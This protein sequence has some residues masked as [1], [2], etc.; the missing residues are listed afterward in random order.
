[1]TLKIALIGSAPSSVALAP[2]DDPSWCI[3]ACSPGARPHLKKVDAFYE[4][5][6]WEP[7]QPWFAPEYVNWMANL[8]CPV[9]MLEHIDAIPP[10]VPYPKD[11]MLAKYGPFFFTSSLSWMFA[12]AIEAGATEIA[13]FGVDMS[14]AEEIYTHQRAGCHF[15]IH[16]AMKRGIKVT[17]P[18]QSDLMRPS[19]LYGFCEQDHLHQKMLAREAELRQRLTQ[20]QQQFEQSRNDMIYLQGALEDVRYVRNTWV[21][22]R[23]AIDMTV[24]REPPAEPAQTPALAPLT[25]AT[26]PVLAT[27]APTMPP[28]ITWATTPAPNFI[29]GLDG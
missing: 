28:P 11:E 1:M 29:N 13:L 10:S 15:F 27:E 4:I 18:Q 21:T 9:Y 8:K 2:Y 26:I 12:M 23:S 6:L 3:W 17:V 14:A 7:H 5:H 25:A 24:W 19:P 22:D 20:A 16:E